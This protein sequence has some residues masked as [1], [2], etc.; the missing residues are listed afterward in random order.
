MATR[1]T[2]KRSRSR[3]PEVLQKPRG[4]FH[5]RVQLVG[6]EHF[7]I[8][9]FDCAKARSKWQLCDFYGNVLVPPTTVEHNRQQ[10]EAA[11]AQIRQ[12]VAHHDL[13]DLLVAIERT[14]R[15]HRAPQRACAAAGLE[16]RLVH[17]FATVQF[18]QPRD[19]NEKTDDNDL[20]AIHLA[21]V[22]GFALLEHDLDEQW[23]TLQLLERHR[24]DLVFKT[25]QLCCQ[26]REHLDAAFPGFAACFANLWDRACAWHLLSHFASPHDLLQAGL[27]GLARCLDDADVG[28][29]DRSLRTV[30]EWAAQAAAPDVA[31]AQH[32]RIALALNDDR[33]RKTQEIQALERELAGLLARTAYLPLLAIPGINVVSAADFAGEMGPISHYAN[34]RA[35]TGRAGLCPSRYQSDRVDRSNGPLRR[36]CNRRLRAAIVGIADNLVTCNHHFGALAQRWRTAGKSPKEIRIRVALRFCRIAYQI[37]AG[38]QPFRH[39]AAQE[40]HYVLQKLLAFHREHETDLP[41]QQRDLLAAVEQLPRSQYQ[42]EAKP[43][44]EE[45]QTILTGGRRGPQLLGDI[46]PIVLARLG[47]GV[48]QSSG[49][50]ETDRT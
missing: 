25:S 15:Y 21:A 27:P 26:I 6:P 40:R 10:F 8:V 17:P 43:L 1:S 22:N 20:A 16:T 31:A 2:R 23:K 45:L 39:P 49:S 50:G 33:L 35:I 11:L 42:A 24:R 30:L 44:Q 19:P 3:N 12:A 7:G 18:R 48:V 14:G 38:R 36:R 46:L 4:T 34:A 32:R 37:V 9:A 29:H 28:Y 5:P 13:R 41:T 47:V